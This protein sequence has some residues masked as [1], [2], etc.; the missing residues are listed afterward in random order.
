MTD[1]TTHIDLRGSQNQRVGHFQVKFGIIFTVLY[2]GIYMF[3]A[4]FQVCSIYGLT[5]FTSKAFYLYEF[6]SI[7]FVLFNGGFK[8]RPFFVSERFIKEPGP[9]GCPDRPGFPP[10]S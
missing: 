1:N 6:R 5:G 2:F 7:L 8:F 4:D 9:A 3:L 10:P